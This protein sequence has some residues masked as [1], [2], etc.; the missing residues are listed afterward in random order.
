VPVFSIGGWYD[1]FLPGQLRDFNIL[2]DAGRAPRLMVGP[3]TH[4]DSDGLPIRESIE[5]A[6]AHARGE[7]PPQ[8]A[9]VRLFVMG[10]E[11]WR[12]F[13]SWPPKGHAPQRFHLQGDGALS[14]GAPAESEPDRY[15][16]DPSDP[17]PAAGG[18]VMRFRG[19]GRVDNKT[20]ATACSASP[21]PT[22]SLAPRCGCG[23]R[24]IA[25]NGVIAS[26]S[27]SPAG[28]SRALRATSAP[29]NHTPPQP[30]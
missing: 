13:D 30:L 21:A 5:F 14:T 12:D 2:Q 10:E 15:R 16:Y 17:T 20:S 6:L 25:S 23:R 24:R 26:A 29:V 1:I 18:V 22:R 3:W 9:P 19:A 8:R 7:Q 28:L 27:K 4:L 11:A